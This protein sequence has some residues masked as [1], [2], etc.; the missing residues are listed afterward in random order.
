V[1]RD[2]K[3]RSA[4]QISLPTSEEIK[5]AMVKEA[6][7]KDARRSTSDRRTR[8]VVVFMIILFFQF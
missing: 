7:A 4:P 5:E 8:Y 3:L 6:V 1:L 2:T